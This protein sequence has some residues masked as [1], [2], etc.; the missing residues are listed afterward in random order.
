MSLSG[1]ITWGILGSVLIGICALVF[2]W[3]WNWLKPILETQL[4][5]GTGQDVKINGDLHGHLGP[6]SSFEVGG[7][8]VDN[9]NW[10][11]PDAD[12]RLAAIE[13]FKLSIDVKQLL[14]GH[15][16]FPE[17]IV[18]KPDL[19]LRRIAIGES[20]WTPP[21]NP[22]KPTKR[23]SLPEVGIIRIENGVI[24][25]QDK[26][27]GM[28]LKG[29][30]STVEGNGGDGHAEGTTGFTLSGKGTVQ[31]DALTIKASG[32]PLLD[33]TNT[34]KPYPLSIDV[35][36]LQTEVKLDG[37]I[38]DPT[39]LSGIDAT[40]ELKGPSAGQL[41]PLLNIPAPETP[42]YH[43]KGHL[44][45]K[46]GA[47]EYEKFEGTVGSSDLGGTLEVQT[48]QPKLFITGVLISKKLD[49]AD[50]GPLV[51][52]PPGSK[53]QTEEQKKGAEQYHADPRILPDA[54]LSLGKVRSVDADVDWKVASVLAPNLP[55]NKVE[56]HVLLNNGILDLNPLNMDVAG[57]AIKSRIKINAQKDEVQTDYDI[58]FSEFHLDEFLGKGGLAG[59]GKGTIS[60][61]IQL[62]APGNSVRESL[63]NAN[64]TLG[65]EMG[66]GEISDLAI[67]LIG[68]DI[69]NALKLFVTQDKLIPIRCI[70]ASFDVDNGLMKPQVLVFDTDSTLVT[71]TGDIN[72]KDE[73]LAL[74]L[75]AEQKSPSL[76]AAPTPIHID[77]TF[78]K[79]VFSLDTTVL[80]ERGA[81]AVAL[82][83]VLTPIGSLLA[84]ID[85][86]LAE[87]SDCAKELAD[88]KNA[89]KEHPATASPV[90]L[91]PAAH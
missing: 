10:K 28:T 18:T 62:H 13:D 73:G 12:K 37:A 91:A 52:I 58:R 2:F 35:T 26:V 41:F 84:F 44:Y 67:S 9:P 14:K 87:D 65:L 11:G 55:L 15:L 19:T 8:T 45:H 36:L 29:A 88:V 47:W 7:I 40:L 20:N 57:G 76:L 17:I 46:D 27:K 23:S 30:L 64:G 16:S 80:I 49:F 39:K 56:L 81:A 21:E 1:K 6:I 66:K 85:P 63:G 77:G 59:K 22:D 24:D 4:S 68:I 61:R 50:I 75:T 42:P 33:L 3:Q 79:P 34:S 51:G 90:N 48:E 69:G 43:I 25:Y 86:G 70:A 54:K 89:P 83:V 31:K 72:L 5:H 71:G 74:R 53:A 38:T 60:G 78:K 82:G 32:G